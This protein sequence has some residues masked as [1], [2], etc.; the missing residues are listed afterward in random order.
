MNGKLVAIVDDNPGVVKTIGE[1][2]RNVGFEVKGL[3]DAESL[4]KYLAKEKPDLIILDF[5]LP[6]MDGFEACKSL[7]GN[8]KFSSIP[9]IILSGEGTEEKDKISGLDL[10]ADDYVIKPFSLNELN[11]RIRAVLR[12]SQQEGEEET[13]KIGDSLVM[14][15]KKYEVT[16][17]GKKIELTSTEFKILEFLASRKGQVFTRDRILDYLWGEEKIVVERTIDVHIRHLREKLGK[18]GEFIKNVRGVGYKLD[19]EI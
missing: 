17:G 9:I 11:A 5:L 18:A 2:L 10:G 13:I 4:F 3:S 16:A 8:E 6:G 15:L 19:E 1:Y 12:R 14:D 7:K